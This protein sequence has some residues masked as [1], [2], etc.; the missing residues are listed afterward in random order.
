MSFLAMLILIFAFVRF[1]RLLHVR[2]WHCG[3]RLDWDERRRHELRRVQPAPE[4]PRVSAFEALK[5]RYV[6]GVITDSQY[7]SELDR[8]LRTPDGR[9]EMEGGV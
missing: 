7:E 2:R 6:R 1:G 5:D 3:S 8:L 4:P 9:R